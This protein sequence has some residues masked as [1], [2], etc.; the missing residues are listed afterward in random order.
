MSGVARLR[1]FKVIKQLGK[2]AY[3][4]VYKVERRGDDSAFYALKKVCGSNS[5]CL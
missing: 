2:G 5:F 3:G 1:D 4:T